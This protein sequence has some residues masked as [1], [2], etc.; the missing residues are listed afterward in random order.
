MRLFKVEIFIGI[1]DNFYKKIAQLISMKEKN[2]SLLPYTKFPMNQKMKL[3]SF[4]NIKLLLD[5]ILKD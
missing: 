3:I 1:E 4:N 2:S 5:Y